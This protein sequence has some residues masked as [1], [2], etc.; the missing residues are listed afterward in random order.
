MLLFVLLSS[1]YLASSSVPLRTYDFF[2]N[3]QFS[4]ASLPEPHS[5]TSVVLSIFHIVSEQS[6]RFCL[7]C[8]QYHKLLQSYVNLSRCAAPVASSPFERQNTTHLMS[9]TLRVTQPYFTDPDNILLR[10]YCYLAFPCEVRL[11]NYL[12]AFNIHQFGCMSRERQPSYYSP[13]G[14]VAHPFGQHT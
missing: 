7:I 12:L 8:D 14:S 6:L 4:L 11:N 5:L 9:F 2:P 3:N 13:T 10:L 1:A